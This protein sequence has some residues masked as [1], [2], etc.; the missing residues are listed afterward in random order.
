MS[1]DAQSFCRKI[2]VV[3]VK[4]SAIAMPIYTYDTLQNQTFPQ[5]K[6]PKFTNL[7]LREVLNTQAHNYDPTTWENDGD[8]AQLRVLSTPKFIEVFQSGVEFYLSGNWGSAR[9]KLEEA[10]DLMKDSDVGG[11]GP[12]RTLLNYMRARDWICPPDWRGY[13]PLTS[14]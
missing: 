10:D 8:L 6:T 11:D 7:S 14:K 4:G 5:L 9:K 1:S 12:S 13:R 2:D 3:T